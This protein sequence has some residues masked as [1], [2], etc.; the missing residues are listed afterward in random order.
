MTQDAK[1]TAREAAPSNNLFKSLLTKPKQAVDTATKKSTKP[2]AEASD[3]SKPAS[4]PF[5]GILRKPTQVN[6]EGKSGAQQAA[7]GAAAAAG[8]PQPVLDLHFL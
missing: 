4:N 8:Q 7:G 3:K 6:Q 2:A 1:A 5:S